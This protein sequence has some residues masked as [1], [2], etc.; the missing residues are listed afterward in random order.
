MSTEEERDWIMAKSRRGWMN[1]LGAF[2]V[3]LVISLNVSGTNPAVADESKQY[4]LMGR[5]T[6]SAFACSSLAW[7]AELR[8]EQERLFKF[9]YKQGQDFLGALK[10]EKI[11]QEDLS[12]GPP[13]GM[14]LLLWGPSPDF[15]LGRVY[16]RA[17]DSALEDVLHVGGRYVHR[18]EDQ[19]LFAS[20]KYF[21]ENCALVGAR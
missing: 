16:E 3:G 7:K 18:K 15:I 6:W 21:R 11:K 19:Q 4:A 5:A 14:L 20:N 8:Q 17:T 13:I 2:C 12:S 1:C 10:A 9:G